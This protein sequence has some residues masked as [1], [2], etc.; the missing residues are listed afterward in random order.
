MFSKAQQKVCVQQRKEATKVISEL[1]NELR[2]HERGHV[3][4]EKQSNTVRVM[5]ENVNSLGVFATG[6]ARNRKLRQLRHV[7]KEYEVDMTSFVE[8]QVDWRHAGKNRQFDV[9]FGLGKERRSVA[10]NNRTVV[11]K[12]S[13]RDQAGG[14][15]MMTTGRT[16]GSVKNTEM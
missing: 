15:A 6:K 13:V 11:K 1:V 2:E 12:Y 5:F 9:L 7:I 4:K 10:A 3:E 16:T 14:V 8:T